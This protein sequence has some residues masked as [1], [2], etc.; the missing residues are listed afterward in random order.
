MG[1]CNTIRSYVPIL[2]VW[3]GDFM[4]WGV[5]VEDILRISELLST[6]DHR[7]DALQQT[8][9]GSE[10]VKS[11]YVAFFMFGGKNAFLSH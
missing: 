9:R 8:E 10:A 2:F 7:A 4:G 11:L 1:I 3:V 6:K 5:I